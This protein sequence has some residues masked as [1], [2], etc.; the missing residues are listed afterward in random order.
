MCIKRHFKCYEI[1]LS[2]ICLIGFTYQ[3]CYL[4]EQYLS[5]E[6]VVNIQIGQKL[7]GI[8]AITVML[9]SLSLDKIAGYSKE[10][11]ELYKQFINFTELSQNI[12]SYRLQATDVYHQVV[13]EVEKLIEEDKLNI[14]QLFFNYTAHSRSIYN[15]SR[16]NSTLRFMGNV[17]LNRKE[18][19]NFNNEYR[20]DIDPDAS[21]LYDERL[22]KCFTVFS[23]IHRTWSKISANFTQIIIDIEFDTHSHPH[24][25]YPF[26]L[27]FHSPLDMPQTERGKIILFRSDSYYL[28]QYHQIRIERLGQQYDTDCF[29]YGIGTKYVT[30]NDCLLTCHQDKHDLICNDKS[31]MVRSNFLVREELVKLNPYRFLSNCGIYEINKHEIYQSCLKECKQPCTYSYYPVKLQNIAELYFAQARLLAEHNEMPDILIK[32]YP[33]TSFISFVCDFGGL[34]GMWLGLSFLTM[35]KDLKQI[36]RKFITF[37]V[38]FKI[39]QICFSINCIHRNDNQVTND[40]IVALGASL[41]SERIPWSV[42]TRGRIGV[43]FFPEGSLSHF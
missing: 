34:L 33:K 5:G 38:I 17:K 40:N 32:Y 41:G 25:Y 3:T 42:R 12:S 29:E 30:M 10:F 22:W 28:A 37:N 11:D 6:T 24:M 16:I 9:G 20:V 31:R 27:F 13:D 19:V 43:D 8:P 7:D 23:E 36:M 18:K 26:A 1:C 15:R 39:K 4:F 21:L 35:A 14:G 2:I